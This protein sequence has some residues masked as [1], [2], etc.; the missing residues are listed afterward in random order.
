MGWG[1]YVNVAAA[2]REDIFE[3]SNFSLCVFHNHWMNETELSLVE[4]KRAQAK[5][6]M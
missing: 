6:E 2:G 4:H 5:S 3:E 1:V